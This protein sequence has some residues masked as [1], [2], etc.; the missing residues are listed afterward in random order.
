MLLSLFNFVL[1]YGI[2]ALA[3]AFPAFRA[4]RFS[5]QRPFEIRSPLSSPGRHAEAQALVGILDSPS[6]NAANGPLRNYQVQHPILLPKSGGHSCSMKLLEHDFGN[7]YCMLTLLCATEEAAADPN[8]LTA[9]LDQ[10]KIVE[11]KPAS[12]PEDCRH[13]WAKIVL[14]LTVTSNGTQFDRLASISL[15][16]VESQFLLRFEASHCQ[17]LR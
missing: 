16:H 10:P 14:N 3:A 13:S 9:T 8:T 7:S 2:V 5:A 11:W 12:L 1:L 6:I 17:N 4:P 15:S